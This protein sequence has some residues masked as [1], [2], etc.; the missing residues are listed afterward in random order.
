[1]EF[2]TKQIADLAGVTVRTLRYYHEVGL[3][4][5]PE[6]SRGGGLVYTSDHVLRLLRI[7]RLTVMGLTLD[8]VADIVGNPT[9]PRSMRLLIDLDRA[10]AD[11][12]AEIQS[13][14]RAIWELRQ[15]QSPVDVLP[16]F[17]RFVAGLRR[18]DPTRVS[19]QA[20]SILVDTVAGFV[21]PAAADELSDLLDS[22]MADLGTAQLAELEERLRTIGPQASEHE[23]AS[24]ALDYGRV[25]T[26]L[27][28]GFAG[29]HLHNLVWSGDESTHPLLAA[30]ADTATNDRQRDVLSRATTV[31]AAHTVRRLHARV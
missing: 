17:A 15:T 25:L 14:R 21:D 30:L 26:D 10:L 7:K 19:D 13:Q 1:L 3:L 4:P 16:E 5:E 28:D 20:N 2:T 8:Q 24:L 23:V 22:V 12:A 27:Y 11:R 18:L 29:L 9:S 31:L 6:R